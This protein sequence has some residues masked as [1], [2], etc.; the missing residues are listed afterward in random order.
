MEQV[1]K[2]IKKA[3]ILLGTFLI[4]MMCS[5]STWAAVS[6]SGSDNIEIEAGVPYKMD[7][8]VHNEKGKIA[9]TYNVKVLSCS[10]NLHV[11]IDYNAYLSNKTQEYVYVVG[12]KP[13]QGTFVI[14]YEVS[15]WSADYAHYTMTRTVHVDV[16]KSSVLNIDG[17]LMSYGSKYF[18]IWLVNNS[19][20][21]VT[22]LS[23][24][25]KAY[26]SDY[27]TFDRKLK[28]KKTTLKPGISKLL[29]LKT[30]K[31]AWPDVSDYHIG[32]RVKFGKRK[33]QVVLWPGVGAPIGLSGKSEIKL[34]KSWKSPVPYQNG[35]YLDFSVNGF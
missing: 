28:V 31:A 11:A 10:Q 21:P 20:K 6:F 16:K 4:A 5:L 22:V 15:D 26:D 18:C 1:K 24:G 8:T 9:H 25:A 23:S 35:R 32:I 17:C 12:N 13:G 14:Q 7:M 33:Y 19:A 3:I 27:Y 34:G 2:P 29:Y 30:N